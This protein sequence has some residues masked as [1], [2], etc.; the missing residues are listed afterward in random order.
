GSGVNLVLAIA[1]PS[2]K[3]SGIVDVAPAP[4]AAPAQQPAPVAVPEPVQQPAAVMA[5]AP[6]QKPA[7][8]VV[9]PPVVVPPPVVVQPPPPALR[10][11]PDV[12]GVDRLRAARAL[13]DAGLSVGSVTEEA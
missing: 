12:V 6:V 7:P 4:A 1:A 5:P 13:R 3:T 10:Q 9:S 8:V 2:G 11:V